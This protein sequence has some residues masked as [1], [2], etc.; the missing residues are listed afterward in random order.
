MWSLNVVVARPSPLDVIES[1]AAEADGEMEAFALDRA[2]ERFSKSIGVWRPAR[3]RDDPGAL[4]C[5]DGIEA[6]AELGVGVTRADPHCRRPVAPRVH[7]LQ[8]KTCSL[9]CS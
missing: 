2:D 4:R 7:A 6:R 9:S 3:D 5:P 1:G 8:G